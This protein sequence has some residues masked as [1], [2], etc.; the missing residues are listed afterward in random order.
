M[1]YIPLRPSPR[2]RHIRAHFYSL[3]APAYGAPRNSWYRPASRTTLTN[4]STRN[5]A[6]LL[7]HHPILCSTVPYYSCCT[8]HTI[9]WLC[10]WPLRALSHRCLNSHSPDTLLNWKPRTTWSQS[11]LYQHPSPDWHRRRNYPDASQYSTRCGNLGGIM[12]YPTSRRHEYKTSRKED[13]RC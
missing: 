13:R 5:T 12:T 2:R 10:E 3:R 9:S 8:L 6:Y 1:L 4:P 7:L 11:S